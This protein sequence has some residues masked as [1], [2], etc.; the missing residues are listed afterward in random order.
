MRH[1]ITETTTLLADL[2]RSLADPVWPPK[3][4]I[5]AMMREPILYGTE[6]AQPFQYRD[7]ASLKYRDDADWMRQNKG[8]TIA[9]ATSIMRAIE[10][11]RHDN[12][13]TFFS[14]LSSTS[15]PG[16]VP[17]FLSVFVFSAAEIHN[18]TRLPLDAIHSFIDCFSISSHGNADFLKPTDF[19][20]VNATPLIPQ[21]NDSVLLVNS[22]SLAEALYTSPFYWMVQSSSYSDV[23]FRHRGEFCEEIVFRRLQ[24]VFGK[25]TFRNVVIQDDRGRHLGEIDVL[26]IFGNCV[27]IVQAKSKGLTYQARQGCDATLIDDFRKSIQ[28]AYD[29][30]VHCA[31]F[32]RDNNTLCQAGQSEIISIPSGDR[33]IYLC[34]VTSEYYPSLDFQVDHLLEPKEAK[35][36]VWPPYICDIFTLDT[37]TEMLDSPLRFLS[38]LDRR[39]RLNDRIKAL[40][41]LTILGV[42]LDQKLWIPDDINLLHLEEGFSAGLDAAMHVR[43]ENVEGSPIPKGILLPFVNSHLG[44]IVDTLEQQPNTTSINLGLFLF[45]LEPDR[46]HEVNQDLDQAM[47]KA[48]TSGRPH[49]ASVWIGRLGTG[50]TV[51]YYG[52]HD[53]VIGQQQLYSIARTRMNDVRATCWFALLVDVHTDHL[54][55]A[56]ELGSWQEA[57]SSLLAAAPRDEPSEGNDT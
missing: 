43:R 2:Q 42:H 57:Y 28:A 8:F 14:S 29:Q 50:I 4:K 16:H 3:R 53:H 22:D 19:N 6:S 27:I 41:E 34:C 7:F 12:I 39:L 44:R 40:H 46:A 32:L 5:G 55:G 33:H 31:R 1:Y 45:C 23:A 37:V 49:S 20:N 15:I 18:I 35:E 9:D 51:L 21:H 26:V 47:K 30:G 17:T 54:V 13:S 56:G 48:K 25:T 24:H 52:H 10:K 11:I 38:Y 36:T